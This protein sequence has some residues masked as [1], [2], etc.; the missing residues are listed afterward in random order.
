MAEK[1]K[2]GGIAET[3]KTVFW[4][5]VLA[6]M[7]RTLL[8]Q[9]FWIPSGSMKP[10]L[11]IGD[12]LFVNKFVYG[13]SWASCPTLF[14]FDFCWF[15]KG[16]D[17]RV[18]AGDPQR[19]DIIVFKHPETET[20]FIK[21]VVGLPGD[22][23]Q[24]K[25]GTLFINNTPVEQSNPGTFVEIFGAQGPMGSFPRCSNSPV[26]IGG[27]CEKQSFDE[28]LPGGATHRTLNI[29]P[30]PGDNTGAFI[31]PEGHF[32]FVGD[33]RDNSTDSRFRKSVGGVGF[34]PA[35]YLIGRADRVIFSSAGR[36]ILYF[37]S[38][39]PDRYLKGLE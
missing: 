32:F 12:F 13:Y 26:G 37:W 8:F 23:V 29:G 1:K 21:R 20:D 19:G 18:W 28:S 38:W 6:G 5:L 11:L 7:I 27:H 30:G 10:T 4:A 9:P 35:S 17:G 22:R 31:V 34:V 33:N 24:M 2:G 16:R 39:R 3:I 36:S 25:N 15:A 14:G